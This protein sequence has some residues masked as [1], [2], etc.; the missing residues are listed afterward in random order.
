MVKYTHISAR[1]GVGR[2]ATKNRIYNE[3]VG[4]GTEKVKH[5]SRE[6]FVRRCVRMRGGQRSEGDMGHLF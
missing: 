4:G 5:V 2:G 3:F 1:D 6:P